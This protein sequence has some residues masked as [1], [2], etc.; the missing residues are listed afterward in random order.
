MASIEVS[1]TS[2]A[3]T[4]T[5]M[6]TEGKKAPRK[7]K[8]VIEADSKI[9]RE[10]NRKDLKYSHRPSVVV[11]IIKWFSTVLLFLLLLAFVN[12]SKVGSISL[13]HIMSRG[14]FE[15][16]TAQQR[17][18]GILVLLQI[19]TIVPHVFSFLRGILTG[20]LRKDIPWPSRR[21]LIGGVVLSVVESVGTTLFVFCVPGLT[22]PGTTVLLMSGVFV[23]PVLYN[24]L[25]SWMADRGRTAKFF[26]T[27]ALAFELAGL[28]LAGYTFANHN[29]IPDQDVGTVEDSTRFGVMVTAVLCLSV[30]WIPAIQ[31][32][33]LNTGS[34]ADVTSEQ[35]LD[36]SDAFARE[37]MGE[38]TFVKSLA[39]S[40]ET[41]GHSEPSSSGYQS[42]SNS[43]PM[44]ASVRL[45]NVIA[46]Q[47]AQ[48]PT[49]K[50][51]PSTWKLTIVMSAVKAVCIFGFSILFYAWMLPNAS[52]DDWVK[53]WGQMSQLTKTDWVM[54]VGN[55]GGTFF[56]YFTA[57]I[58]CTTRMQRFGFSV[59]LT[60]FSTPLSYVTFYAMCARGEAN[61]TMYGDAFS[62]SALVLLV[63]A[64]TLSNGYLLFRS[65]FLAMLKE[66]QLF[67]TPMY[68]SGLLEQWLILSK[69]T[70]YHDEQHE[71]PVLKASRTKVI[72][73]T[74][75][76]READYEM[77]QLLQSINGIHRAQTDGVRKFESH[78]F[79]DGAVKDVNPTD[80]VLQLISL[81]EEELGVTATFCTRTRTP[82]GLSVSWNLNT[83]HTNSNMVF[84]I[85]LKDNIK[86]K[87]KKRWSQ[88]MYMSYVLDFIL[89]Q[90]KCSEEECFILTT[91][92]DVRFNVNSVEALLDL[93]TRDP[94]VGAVCARTHPLGSGPL[95]WYQVFEYAI[96]HWFQ[97]AAEHVI[98]S[99]LCSP[100]C[101]S[102]YRCSAIR[103]ILPEYATNVEHAFDFLTKDM[104]EDRW[105]CTLM[106]QSGWRIEYCA[107]AENS[108][109]CPEDFDEFFKQRRRW[110]ASTLANLMLLVKEWSTISRLNP[111]VSAVFLLY[112]AVLLFATLI[113]PSSIILVVTGGLTY[114]WHINPTTTVILQLIV[115]VL[116][117]VICLTT[118]SKTQLNTAKLLTFLYAIIMAA[119]MVGTAVQVAKDISKAS[120]AAL[121]HE[122]FP[123]ST[124]TLYLAI[125]VGIFLLTG[126]M[127]PS[128][129][130]CLLHGF[131]FFLCIPAGY[132]ILMI[133]SICNITDQS[134]GTREVKEHS[135][136]VAHR[137]WQDRLTA[138]FKEVFFCCF[139]RRET[140]SI[141]SQ[142]EAGVRKPMSRSGSVSESSETNTDAKTVR[143]FNTSEDG[144]SIR[145]LPRIHE[146]YDEVEDARV[147]FSDTEEDDDD[148]KINNEEGVKV[149]E[150]LTSDFDAYESVVQ[151][152]KD[153]GFEN[154]IFI[155][156]MTDKE[157][158]DMGIKSSGQKRYL[159]EKI[160]KLPDYDIVADVPKNVKSWLKKIG[161]EMYTTNFK[162]EHINSSKDMEI[163]KSFSRKD[164]QTELKINKIGHIKR[165]MQAIA[166]LRNPT[167][168]ER[169]ILEVR[170]RLKKS[171]LHKMR[172]HQPEEEEFWQTL[173]N[174]CLLPQSTA[175][176]LEEDLKRDLGEL[177][178]KWIVILAVFNTLW[179]VLIYT[180][181]D[182]GKLLSVASSNPVGLV[183]LVVFSFVL[184]VQFIAMIIHR[185][186]TATHFLARAPYRFGAKYRTA[187]ALND[188]D[189]P[190]ETEARRARAE[191]IRM[192]EDR[193]IDGRSTRVAKPEEK[194]PLLR[195][196]EDSISNA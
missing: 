108:T 125:M 192:A 183:V 179:M 5:T 12:F 74:T 63:V 14:V 38:Q 147:S 177:R 111:R 157:L 127:H 84:K 21:S 105:F 100:G 98:G 143:T 189:M 32:R 90:E 154:T 4:A 69:K 184:F 142:T 57:Y 62:V 81:A 36:D 19:A 187:W 166:K 134:W 129:F 31:R 68:T 120:D 10:L 67:W 112:Q 60:L 107:A 110:V 20:A 52:A 93:M 46:S 130:Y 11:V 180:L 85:H 141:E 95:V 126:M 149:E 176:G 49:R 30:A 106:V 91:D 29:K 174:L 83:P 6:G 40:R 56:G 43:N 61:C 191:A 92:A 54:F 113:G 116:Y 26:F 159:M 168:G 82:Y 122:S 96:G 121:I 161:L 17:A 190:E 175:Y 169:K 196:S 97:K 136:R 55:I 39:S 75:M 195:Q 70:E 145:G 139:T 18:Q 163:L 1:T 114:A 102:V 153:N 131:W 150:W 53:G 104:G 15:T 48:K 64:Q 117:A 76:Y 66:D 16:G 103:D 140:R 37:I 194:Q 65:Q 151:K 3:S 162:Q 138:M 87:N 167:S 123:I 23:L 181:A 132:L 109:H 135:V 118:S 34:D 9:K 156:K 33:L 148:D 172:E 128:E 152:F 89:K 51:A 170:Q 13:S 160:K 171:L 50:L 185:I 77:R 88:V 99:V 173:Q 24:A 86:V 25:H 58:A 182:Q 146:E 78:I 119:V 35:T 41:T 115:T 124:T 28:G 22:G 165:L 158:K 178:N 27:V 193:I 188:C 42:I 45:N 79:F 71:D 101:F 155:S 164:I 186:T 80:F 44:R 137:N 8:L 72:I 94:S 7:N 133:Y 2:L 47:P 73:C 59:P 144:N